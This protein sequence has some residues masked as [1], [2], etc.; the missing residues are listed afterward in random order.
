ML[1]QK[2]L[3]G[4]GVLILVSSRVCAEN[5]TLYAADKLN[6][7]EKDGAEQ[8]Y[9]AQGKP[10][11][12]AVELSDSSGHNVIYLYKNGQKNG[13]STIY[14][15]NR[16][17]MYETTYENGAKNGAEVAFYANGNPQYR[18]IYKN[19]ILNGEEI[20]FN[21]A[22]KPQKQSQYTDGVL[23]G[24]VNYFDD[25]GNLNKVETYKNGVKDGVERIVKNN[26]LVA[27]DIYV[28]GR[29]NGVS[30]R[31]SEK[32]LTD[33]IDYVD[34]QREGWHKH[35][36]ED[37][38]R[39]EI[40]YHNNK[41]NGIATL[42]LPNKKVALITMY[43]NDAKNGIEQ[44]FAEDGLLVSAE[45]YRND[46]LDGISRYFS[47][48]GEPTIIKLFKD[49][50]EKAAID[51]QQ[52]E[53]IAPL[54]NKYK[55]GKI[56]PILK[57]RNMWYRILWLG[58]TL[59][60]PE[61][62]DILEK[63]MKMYNFA[64]D[65]M[66]VYQ[67]FGNV[68]YAAQ[69]EGLYFGMTPF[70]YATAVSASPEIVQKFKSQLR[71]AGADGET[72]LQYAVLANNAD[73][74]K[75]M[76]SLLPSEDKNTVNDLLFLAVQN[77]ANTE[78]IE[79]LLQK[80]DVNITDAEG[81][82]PLDYAV[83]N[84][85]APSIIEMFINAGADIT[86][87]QYKNLLV[88]GLRQNK[89]ISYINLLAD[90]GV[91]ANVPDD[92]NHSALYYAEINNYPAELIEKL[93]NKGASWTNA[94]KQD[95]IKTAA[96]QGDFGVLQKLSAEQLSEVTDNGRS[97]LQYAYD[98]GA[99]DEIL[100][101]FLNNG[102]DINH[103]DHDGNTILHDALAK[104]NTVSAQKFIEKGAAIN[105]VNNYGKS[106]ISYVLTDE[107]A[108]EIY[109]DVWAKISAEDAM[110]KMPENEVPLWKYLY[111]QNKW[112]ALK[113]LFA[114]VENPLLLTD[115]NGQ[116]VINLLQKD[117]Q[118]ADFAALVSANIIDNDAATLKAIVKQQQTDLLRK[119]KTDRLDMNEQ[120]EYGETLLTSAYKRGTTPDFLQAL[121][122]K[123]ADINQQNVEGKSVLDIAFNT[124]VIGMIKFMIEHGADINKVNDDRIY[125][126]DCKCGE[127]ELTELFITHN[128]EVSHVT[129][130]GETMLMAAV[131]NLN[132]PL[133]KYVAEH[134]IDAN[135]KDAEGLSAV[136]YL[137]KALEQY[138]AEDEGVRA[139][140]L[141]TLKLLADHGADLNVRDYD[142]Q[143]I[144]VIVASKYPS[145][146]KEFAEAF[147]AAGGNPEIKDQYDKKAEDYI[148]GQ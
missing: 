104:Q 120:D 115:E 32:Y 116:N 59:D 113:T 52:T 131:R 139:D 53:T 75:F 12:G 110:L 7:T 21:E 143:T 19:N 100:Q 94:D 83:K 27:E 14:Y 2:L 82:T 17:P 47:K 132:V 23:N 114:K 43:V 135:A 5:I 25:D 11:S 58:I 61:L 38:S 55:E 24:T 51:L 84:E 142:G 50:T 86:K 40:P 127:A 118:N 146:Y 79:Q 90:K 74:F 119:M 145:F 45:G 137:L 4:V 134:N 106:A 77:G 69:T 72:P 3:Y 138:G 60:K 92:D 57:Q 48:S 93:Q 37:G 87:P 35:F 10:F 13:I 117:A 8:V 88:S 22:G 76:L 68:D 108:A 28:N 78:I 30:K 98:I 91:A 64:I 42:Y 107:K 97:A 96:D 54:Y 15:D 122:D 102:A 9:D 103:Q 129:A 70:M 124:R 73:S 123:G 141:E 111:L 31:Y 109:A 16:K 33:E 121:L 81:F 29:I 136:L 6:F 18:R 80:A 44:K 133:I 112:D 95:L 105:V 128:A 126:M 63:A 20:L 65:D 125:L 148:S 71:T 89:P 147:V 26:S 39:S 101:Y 56:G 144:L 85:A 99:A 34:G 1:L 46:K 130:E 36:A 66:E 140:V 49:G 41:K 67:R 62:V